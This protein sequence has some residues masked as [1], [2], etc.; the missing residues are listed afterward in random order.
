MHKL[1]TGLNR[2]LLRVIY[3]YNFSPNPNILWIRYIS[4]HNT[5]G[6]NKTKCGNLESWDNWVDKIWTHTYDR[7]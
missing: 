6:D 4:L 5:D 1:L 3:N 2:L 7:P